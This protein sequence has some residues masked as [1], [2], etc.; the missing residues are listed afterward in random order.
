MLESGILFFWI[1]CNF[2][3]R[4][5]YERISGLKF[6][7]LFLGLFQP[8]LDRNNARINFFNFLNFFAIFFWNFLAQSHPPF[9]LKIMPERGFSIFWIF[10]LFFSEFSCPGWV[11]TEFRTKIFFFSFSAYLVPFWLKILPEWGFL[12][13]WFFFLIFFG[14][15]YSVRLWTEFGKKIFFWLSRPISSR[16]GQ[17]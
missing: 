7:P 4:V 13:F 9:W 8:V 16:F 1:F 6:F 5:E 15:A 17:K 10:L 2:L 3:F 12:I 14:I 11:L